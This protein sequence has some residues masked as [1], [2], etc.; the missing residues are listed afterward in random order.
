MRLYASQFSSFA[1]KIRVLLIEK[2]VP[3]EVKIVNLW[4]PNELQAVNPLGKVPALQLDDGR[5]L[6]S[7]PLIADYLD[8]RFPEPRFIPPDAEARLEARQLEGL[9]DGAMEAISAILYEMRFHDEG[10]RSDA[11]IEHQRGKFAAALEVLEK[12]LARHAWLAGE[13]VTV[14]DIAIACHLAFIRLRMPDAAPAAR[15]PG[16]ARLCSALEARESFKST[17]PPPS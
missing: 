9:A 1:R 11:W 10:K 17:A 16:L 3:H 6:I 12:R 13:A 14:G 5:V 15:Y 7:S 2:R 4:E 8:S